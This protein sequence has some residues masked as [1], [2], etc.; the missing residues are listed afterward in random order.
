MSY[1]VF[2]DWVVLHQDALT[3]TR[4]LLSD[5][6][7]L[8]LSSDFDAPTFYQTLAGVTHC[9]LSTL[10]IMLSLRCL[11]ASSFL[12]SFHCTNSGSLSLDIYSVFF[13]AV[14]S[15]LRWAENTVWLVVL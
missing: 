4:W 2:R 15:T 13:S 3:I 7:A 5:K 8:S 12:P 14:L 6:S 10:L 1:E 9:T 11:A